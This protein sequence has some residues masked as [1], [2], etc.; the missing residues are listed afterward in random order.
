MSSRMVKTPNAV[1]LYLGV[2]PASFHSGSSPTYRCVSCMHPESSLSQDRVVGV[3][4]PQR[5]RFSP[6]VTD[7]P[8]QRG[9][10]QTRAEPAWPTAN[11]H[12]LENS[13]PVTSPCTRSSAIEGHREPGAYN[14]HHAC[15]LSRR[16][17]RLSIKGS[18]TSAAARFIQ[19][20]K[21]ASSTIAPPK[22]TAIKRNEY[23]AFMRAM[24]YE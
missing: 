19:S 22:K 3:S 5:A 15:E 2:H 18:K 23:R 11:Q 9:A 20:L 21:H 6:E 16:K 17:T 7:T 4:N 13:G 1:L 24:Q 8:A 14:L 10:G 12:T